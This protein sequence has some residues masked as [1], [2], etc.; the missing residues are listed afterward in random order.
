LT[1]LSDKP[2]SRATL[3]NETGLSDRELR[4]EIENARHRGVPI[5]SNNTKGGYHIA[6]DLAEIQAFRYDCISR[7]TKLLNM[8]RANYTI[9]G[10]IGIESSWR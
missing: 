6:S 7:A 3:V 2:K 10:Q 1:Y 4:R 5:V 9:D 8:A